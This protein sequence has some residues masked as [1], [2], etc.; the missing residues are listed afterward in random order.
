MCLSQ[1]PRSPSSRAER[2][3]PVRRRKAVATHADC[4]VCVMTYGRFAGFLA[5]TVLSL[6]CAAN[7][8]AEISISVTIAP[9]ELPVY[10]QPPVP[11]PGYLWTPGYWAY[12]PYNEF[13]HKRPS[14]QTE[15]EL[16]A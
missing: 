10:E 7:A 12:G 16:R 9:P 3:P 4:E 11:G 8:Q 15:T 6:A 2:D 13:E 5:A 14:N 1:A